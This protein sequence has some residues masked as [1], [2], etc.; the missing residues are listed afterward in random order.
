MKRRRKLL[1]LAL[2]LAGV[3]FALDLVADQVAARL[4]RTLDKGPY[5]I[6]EEA[7]RLHQGLVVA[8]LHADSLLWPRDPLA[9]S[10]WGHA[11]LPRLLDGGV[12][13]QG[14]GV[15][16]KTPEKMNFE[17]NSGDTDRI[18]TLA[19]VSKWP[20]RTWG[21]LL[22]RARFQAEKLRD[23]AARSEGGLVLLRTRADLDDLLRRRAAGEKAIGGFL[24]LEGTHVLSG[25]LENLDR[26][27]EEGIRQ[28]GLAHF[29]DNEVSGSAHGMEKGGLSAFGRAVLVRAEKLGIA[30]DLAHASHRAFDEALELSSRPVLVSH[31]GVAGTCGGPRNLTDDQLRRIA[32]KGG[33]VGIALF[34][35]ATCGDDLGAMLRAIDHAKTVAGVGAVAIGSD[36]DGAIVAPFDA[37]GLPLVT[38]GLMGRG[39]S[40]EEIEKILGG[41]VVRFLRATLPPE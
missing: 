13:I 41:N 39:Y 18:R 32:A 40:R 15:V 29:F 6:S 38:Q 25:K 9:R 26:L 35:G 7:R 33:L 5:R 22:E 28:I 23:A 17:R 24:S 10:G 20:P 27:H 21:D 36:F 14:F 19:M 3:Y 11:D 37:S 16:T 34:D 2:G 4:N 1:Y 8:D 30:I 12:A 31:T